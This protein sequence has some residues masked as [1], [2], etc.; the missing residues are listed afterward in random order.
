[1]FMRE[2]WFCSGP[3]GRVGPLSLEQLKEVLARN[4]HSADVYIWHESLPDWIRAGD[5]GGLDHI[6]GSQHPFEDLGQRQRAD[7]RRFDF[8]NYGPKE[9]TWEEPKKRFSIFGVFVGVALMILGC[10]V[11]Y[12]GVIGKFTLV[13]EALDLNG[14]ELDGSAGAVFFVAGLV[15]I[16][17]TRYR[18]T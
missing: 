13:A 3:G 15:V 17:V 5:F 4:P 7:V 1:M 14:T 8:G 9:D 11:F 2:E 6:P 10:V 12:L 18:V 16:G